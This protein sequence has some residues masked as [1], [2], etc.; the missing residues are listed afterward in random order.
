METEETIQDMLDKY[1]IAMNDKGAQVKLLQELLNDYKIHKEQIF[2]DI[3]GY[4]NKPLQPL[5]TR[6]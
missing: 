5:S 3:Q 6:T 1:N 4:L 2:Q